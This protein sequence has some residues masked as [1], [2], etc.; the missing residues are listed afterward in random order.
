MDEVAAMEMGADDWRILPGLAHRHGLSAALA[1]AIGRRRDAPA[2]TL[3]QAGA[4]ARDQAIAALRGLHEL[5]RVVQAL[6]PRGIECVALKGPLLARWLYGDPGFR[7]F[8]DL[9]VAVAARDVARAAA[10]LAPLGYGLPAGMSVKTANAIYGPLGAW[11]L[12]A[13][14]L[15]PLDLHWRIAHVR[16]AATVDVDQILTRSGQVGFGDIRLN[17][18]SPTDAALL[19]LGHAAKHVWCT[20]EMLLAIARLMKRDD[21]NWQEVAA[22]AKAAGAWRGCATGLGLASELFEVPVPPGVRL[23]ALEEIAPLRDAALHALLQPAGAFP[24][25]WDERRAH[26]ASLDRWNARVRYDALRLLSP[27]PLEWEWRP[28]PDAMTALYTPLRLVR[29]GLG[30]FGRGRGESVIDQRKSS[31]ANSAS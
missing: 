16:F 9:D 8:T 25:R 1:P 18:P 2:E 24:D 6:Q 11:P 10:A 4:L 17:V 26:L 23:P 3:D 21:V 28:L 27:T 13:A 14:G 29:L 22:R 5:T 12:A 31:G 19:A 20:L 15:F 7:R 30:A